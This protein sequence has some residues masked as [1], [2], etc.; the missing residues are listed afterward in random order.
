M[1]E[2]IEKHSKKYKLFGF[3][4]IL[5]W[6][7]KDNTKVWKFLG[8]PLLKIRKKDNDEAYKYYFCGIPVM[9]MKQ[10]YVVKRGR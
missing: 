5:S 7:R 10:R 6:K 4:P 2:N 3:L 1:A 9:K 8:L